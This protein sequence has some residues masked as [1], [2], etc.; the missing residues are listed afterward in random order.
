MIALN[1]FEE[2]YISVRQKENRLYTDE[3]VKWLPEIEPSHLHH[4][5]WQIRSNSCNKLVQYLSNK[6]RELN[7]LEVGCG[8]G[9]LCSQLSKI[10][11]SNV[12]GI[13]VNKTELD[14]AKRVFDPIENL[15]FFNCEIVD[16]SIA[17]EKFDAILFAASIQYFPSITETLTMAL[18]LLNPDGEIHILDTFFYKSSELEMARKRSAEYYESIGFP[19]MSNHYFHHC[20]DE[21][22]PYHYKLFHNPDLIINR[23]MKNKNPFHWICIYHHA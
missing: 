23:L 8:N 17:D 19:D 3:Q 1:N 15:E 22:K 9:W 21:L 14:Q 4:K 13:D 6:K 7:I 18:Q 16:E 12:A 11:G 20:I 5:E 10:P 2:Q